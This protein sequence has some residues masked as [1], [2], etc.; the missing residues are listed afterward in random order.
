ME[1]A[2][3]IPAHTPGLRMALLLAAALV[4][5]DD[6]DGGNVEAAGGHQVGR[7]R[8]VAR[9]QADHAVELGAFYG[10]LHVIHDQIARG[11]NV[12]APGTGTD[13]EVAGSGGAD[14]EGPAA[15]FAHGI[16]HDPGDAVEVTEADRELRGGVDHRDLGFQHVLVGEAQC[17]PLRP[18]RRFPR[19]AGLEIATQ[20][21]LHR[22]A[23][24]WSGA[25]PMVDPGIGRKNLPPRASSFRDLRTLGSTARHCTPG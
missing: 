1:F 8:L 18:P 16:L 13:D 21:L 23:L 15:S 10:Y 17:P 3:A 24:R 6:Q 4:A 2:V 12:A 11:E 14:L 9:G 25:H 5:A 22:K 20:G 7:R 19:R